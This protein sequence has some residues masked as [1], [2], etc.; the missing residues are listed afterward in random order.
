MKMNWQHFGVLGLAVATIGMPVRTVLAQAEA[1]SE[2]DLI[3]VV[4][5]IGTRSKPRRYDGEHQE[6][7]TVIHSHA[8]N[9]R[10]QRIR[11]VNIAA[12]IAARRS[13]A[14]RQ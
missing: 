10:W 5:T 14:S 6:S 8:A 4:T 9:G 12:R 3:E 13:F 1:E 11:S 2:D 7:R